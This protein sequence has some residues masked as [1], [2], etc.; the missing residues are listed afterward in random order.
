MARALHRTAWAGFSFLVVLGF[1]ATGLSMK[2]WPT[3]PTFNGSCVVLGS[4]SKRYESYVLSIEDESL[5]K[6]AP[7]AQSET[8][9]GG[10]PFFAMKGKELWL[11][12][13]KA[14]T[15]ERYVAP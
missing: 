15:I 10:Q 13:P 8:H 5:R 9:Q 6:I 3:S 4:I 7:P 12:H 11:L 2:G 1:A 14:R